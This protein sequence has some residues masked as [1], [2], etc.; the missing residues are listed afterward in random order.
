MQYIYQILSHLHEFI[1][2]VDFIIATLHSYQQ[3]HMRIVVLTTAPNLLH[4]FQQVPYQA[5]VSQ[6]SLLLNEVHLLFLGSVGCNSA[7]SHLSLALSSLSSLGPLASTTAIG[8]DFSYHKSRKFFYK[9][10]CTYTCMYLYI[11]IHVYSQ[12]LF[13]CCYRMNIK[14]PSSFGDQ[15]VNRQCFQNWLC[16][17]L[18]LKFDRQFVLLIAGGQTCFALESTL[19]SKIN[20]CISILT[21]L[22]RICINNE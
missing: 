22:L 10:I 17:R 13:Y 4:T 16:P 6:Y 18:S 12:A 20:T 15:L 5:S 9:L 14:V 7:F 1:K 21:H 3:T 8:I 19:H 11:L 2:H